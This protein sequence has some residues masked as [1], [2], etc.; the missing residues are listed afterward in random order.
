MS[1]GVLVSKASESI[2]LVSILALSSILAFSVHALISFQTLS[3]VFVSSEGALYA[4]MT[5]DIDIYTPIFS[6]PEES[7]RQLYTY[8]CHSLSQ[9]KTF[10]FL[11]LK[12]HHQK[13]PFMTQNVHV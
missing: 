1:R 3:P 2:S 12:S 7:L 13:W 10:Y 6:C 9:Y 4:M 11:T 5:Y 8:P